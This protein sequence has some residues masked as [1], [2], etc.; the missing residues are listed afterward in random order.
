MPLF[1]FRCAPCECEFE[2]LV[3]KGEEASCPH[4]GSASIEKLLSEAAPPAA[5]S[6]RAL[7]IA[8]SCPPGDAPCGPGCCRL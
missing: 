4:C 3:R 2:L 5:S 7:S 6:A 1:E 8:S